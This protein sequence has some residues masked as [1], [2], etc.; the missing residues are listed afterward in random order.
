[1]VPRG[2]AQSGDVGRR[3]ACPSNGADP[4]SGVTQTSVRFPPADGHPKPSVCH[5]FLVLES[6]LIVLAVLL[7]L[8]VA[9]LVTT[10]V[11]FRRSQREAD[12]LRAVLRRQGVGVS[13]R[14]RRAQRMR[15]VIERTVDT[16]ARVREV[17][18]TGLLMSSIDDLA[19]WSQEDQ[20]EIAKLAGR[21]GSVS[22]LFS[23]IEDSTA[24]NQQLGDGAWVR[25]LNSHDKLVRD[26]VEKYEGHIVKSQGDGFMIAFGQPAEAVRAGIQ[27]QDALSASR[28]RRLRRT[29][30]RV[31]VGIHCGTAIER[32]GD[33]FGNNV[34]KAA[35]VAALAE[36]GQIL[37][38]DEVRTALRDVDDIVLVDGRESELKGIPGE[39]RLWEVAVI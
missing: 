34:A 5:S 14:E 1:M 15:D 33:L 29:P 12:R 23:D 16:A 39:H 24:L 26:Q 6:I 36:G 18:V 9:A 20:T 35:R 3:Q 19:R 22:I 30:I 10:L 38:S 28:D 32:D 11:R 7:G 17:G 37:V 13:P 25:L 4:P 27:I 8:S 31:R 21:D 2:T